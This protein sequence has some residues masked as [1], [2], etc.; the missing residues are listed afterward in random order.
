MRHPRVHVLAALTLLATALITGC[1]PAGE[2]SSTSAPTISNASMIQ[3][4]RNVLSGYAEFDTDVSA[5]AT[6]TVR[7]EGEVVREIESSSTTTDHSVFV[8]GLR[9]TTDYQIKMTARANGATS[10]VTRSYSTPSLPSDFPPLEVDTSNP[11]LAADGYRLLDV[12]RWNDANTDTDADWGMMVA[13][14][15]RGEVV[16]YYEAGEPVMDANRLPNGNIVYNADPH[17]VVEINMQG[18]EVNRWSASE[19]LGRTLDQNEFG[20]HHGVH[21]LQNGNFLALSTEMRQIDGFLDSGESANV[22]GDVALEFTR[23]GGVVDSWSMFDVLSDYT[24][25]KRVGSTGPFWNS[26]YGMETSDWTH[27][28]AVEPGKE[29]GTLIASLRHQDWIVKWDAETGDLLWRLGPDGDFDMASGE[30]EFNFHQHAP[31]WLENGNLLVYDNGNARPSI[32]QGNQYYTR[33]VEYEVNTS[34][35]DIEAGETGTVEQVWEYKNDPEYYAP[36][37]GDSDELPNGNVLIADGGLVSDPSACISFNEQ[38]EP[39]DQTGACIS[40]GDI[41]KWARL[42]EVTHDSDKQVALE[43]HMRDNSEQNPRSYTMYRASHLDGLY[44][45]N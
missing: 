12:F 17:A 34:N 29:D 26:D 36:Y 24:T 30:G 27:G 8:M 4:P 45:T 40:N 39:V 44:A 33:V 16:W 6:I 32:Q 5:S 37:V 25:R 15:K 42:L 43:I 7:H 1:G 10:S 20:L 13:V 2:D 18:E 38:G 11:D 28:N 23:D 22:V 21:R 9:A 35:V 41:Q 3:N 31:V 19:D 14:D